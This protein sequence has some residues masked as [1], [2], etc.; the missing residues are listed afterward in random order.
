MAP[1]YVGLR[2]T[3]VRDREANAQGAGADPHGRSAKGRE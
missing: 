3:L 1:T 2:N